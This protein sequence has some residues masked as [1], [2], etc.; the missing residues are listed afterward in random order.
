[1][2]KYRELAEKAVAGSEADFA[3]IRLLQTSRTTVTQAGLS[4]MNNGPTRQF[5][6]AARVLVS[7]R[8]GIC[9]F[10]SPGEM[11]NALDRAAA[12]AIHS[13]SSPVPFPVLPP[14]CRDTYNEEGDG[15]PLADVTL[16]EKSF[17][18]RH[19]CE[20][21]GASLSTGSA[22]VVYEE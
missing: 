9:E 1:M 8:W 14:A 11:N 12:L 10:S 20:L 2:Q 4:S 13:E 7:N 6:G 19:Y 17:L 5:T 3:E 18:C 21:L 15:V 22:R 16:R